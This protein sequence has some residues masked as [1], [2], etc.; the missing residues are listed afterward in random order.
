VLPK[1]QISTADVVVGILDRPERLAVRHEPFERIEAKLLHLL[2]AVRKAKISGA[3][4]SVRDA[5]HQHAR[6]LI[7]LIE[8]DSHH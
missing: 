8:R 7:E 2:R 5:L 4:P 6:E 3:S 1:V